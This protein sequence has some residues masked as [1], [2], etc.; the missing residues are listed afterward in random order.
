[1]VRK[2]RFFFVFLRFFAILY[3]IFC[4]L[5][6]REAWRIQESSGLAS[7]YCSVIL[8]NITNFLTFANFSW[9]VEINLE[10]SFIL[11]YYT[12]YLQSLRRTWCS[13]AVKF[14]KKFICIFL[15]KYL[16]NP[17]FLPT[18]VSA[19]QKRKRHEKEQLPQEHHHP[20]QLSHRG[21][22]RTGILR[23]QNQPYRQWGK[24]HRPLGGHKKGFGY[25]QRGIF[26][27]AL[28]PR[29]CLTSHAI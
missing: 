24:A 4:S 2:C 19:N 6:A 5:L 15:L 20:Q 11:L 18:F 17:I 1:M 25:E 16:D 28:S 21:L 22:L 10:I 9:G 26:R 12:I 8:F 23:L 7:T 14:L 3:N 13:S 27:Y 29:S